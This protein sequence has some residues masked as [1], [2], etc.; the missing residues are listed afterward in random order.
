MIIPYQQL[1][2]E[3][4]YS[5]IEEFVTRNNGEGDSALVENVAQVFLQLQKGD[6]VLVYDAETES[7]NLLPKHEIS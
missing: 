7:C 4:L 6:I 1:S 3:A 5:V 2:K